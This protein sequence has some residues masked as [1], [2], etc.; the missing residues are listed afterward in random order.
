MKCFF[1]VLEASLRAATA[2]AWHVSQESEPLLDGLAVVDALD[3]VM[4]AHHRARLNSFVIHAVDDH[5]LLEA[6]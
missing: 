4:M 6:S 3:G 1:A 5:W 2:R